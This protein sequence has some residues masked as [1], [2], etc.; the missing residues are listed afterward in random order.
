VDVIRAELLG[1]IGSSA[2][3]LRILVRLTVASLL[4]GLVGF[5]RQR[6]GKAAG[7]RTHMLVAL[8]SALFALVPLEAGVDRDNLG[9]VIQGIA[10]GIGFLGAGTILKLSDLHEIKGLTTAASIWMTAAIGV[11]VGSGRIGL[12]LL[13]V[14]LGLFILYVLHRLEIWLQIG[15]D[16]ARKEAQDPNRRDGTSSQARS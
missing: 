13:S 9:R 14:G 6:E 8:G 4:G 15:Q 1:G 3:L 11:A 16:Q 2:E 5:E 7:T 12:A 10:A